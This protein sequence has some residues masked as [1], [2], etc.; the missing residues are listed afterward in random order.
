[1]SSINTAGILLLLGIILIG[2]AIKFYTNRRLKE[3][4]GLGSVHTQDTKEE[5]NI[6]I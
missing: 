5:E 4:D 3:I 2:G 6:Y 1:M